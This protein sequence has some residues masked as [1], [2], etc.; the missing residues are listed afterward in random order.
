MKLKSIIILI[1]IGTMLLLN[2]GFAAE[3]I[4]L[5]E[6]DFDS[7][8]KMSIPENLTLENMSGRVIGNTT[9][10]VNY[11][12]EDAKISIIYAESNGTKAKL[13]ESYEKMCANDTTANLTT[14]NN[15]TVVH[16]SDDR[17]IG[18]VNYHDLAIAG[19]DEKYLLIQCDNET[20]MNMMVKS[21][22]FS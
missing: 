21:I 1:A 18:E 4:T 2:A 6:H 3:N 16:F 7:H 13:V 15:T 12:N 5:K 22:K 9:L 17:T 8:F 20:L 19:D 10:S 14:I 11:L